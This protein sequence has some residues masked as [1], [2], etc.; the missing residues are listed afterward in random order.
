MEY[1]VLDFQLSQLESH[2]IFSLIQLVLDNLKLLSLEADGFAVSLQVLSLL[3]HL[4]PLHLDLPT[5]PVH[6]SLEILGLA[7]L[8]SLELTDLPVDLIQ[9]HLALPLHALKVTI[10]L[11]EPLNLSIQFCQF[12]VKILRVV[13]DIFLG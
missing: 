9:G 2:V 1:L 6:P 5:F 4:I 3:T 12:R 11:A 13:I 8:A 10:L 7:F